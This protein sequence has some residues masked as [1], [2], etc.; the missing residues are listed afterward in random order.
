[1]KFF[2]YIKKV[3]GEIVLEKQEFTYS[4]DGKYRSLPEIIKKSN[5]EIGDILVIEYSLPTWKEMSEEEA[6]EILERMMLKQ[7]MDQSYYMDLTIIATESGDE[8]ID[9][10]DNSVPDNP[11]DP[12]NTL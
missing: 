3:S 7:D 11:D 9:Q 10:T 2:A 1:M 6:G 8:V 5:T 12:K 4:G